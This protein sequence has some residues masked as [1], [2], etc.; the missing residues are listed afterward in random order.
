M[1]SS[2]S[3]VDYY[4][5]FTSIEKG[6]LYYTTIS[7]GDVRS[8]NLFFPKGGAG[9]PAFIDFQLLKHMAPEFDCFYFYT[10]STPTEWRQANDLEL[11]NVC[12]KIR[13]PPP[14]QPRIYLLDRTQVGCFF[15]PLEGGGAKQLTSVCPLGRGS[16]LLSLSADERSLDDVIAFKGTTTR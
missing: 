11:M 13:R 1:T 8:E 9:A 5:A 14:C 4:L 15:P 10:M 2:D 12:V 3:K 6:G 16:L 7:H